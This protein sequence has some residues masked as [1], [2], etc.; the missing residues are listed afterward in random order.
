IIRSGFNVYPPEVEAVLNDHPKVTQTAVIGAPEK[1]GEE[2]ILAYVQVSPSNPPTVEE[3]RQFCAGKL[4]P[5]KR[6][7]RFVLCETLPAGPTGKVLKH[8]LTDLATP[9]HL[10]VDPG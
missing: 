7:S 3:L 6:P 5:Y 2:E 8:R 1:D 4:A 10:T 9:L